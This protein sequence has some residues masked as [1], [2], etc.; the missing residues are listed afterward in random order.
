MVAVPRAAADAWRHVYMGRDPVALDAVLAGAYKDLVD[1]VEAAVSACGPTG[2]FVRLSTRS[3]KDACDKLPLG[4][5]LPALRR[6]LQQV[7]ELQQLP[8]PKHAH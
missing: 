7:A 8:R 4:V 5:L 3:P 1:A 2:A 6:E